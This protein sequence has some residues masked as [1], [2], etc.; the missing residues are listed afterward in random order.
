MEFKK[1][2]YCTLSKEICR[3]AKRD[4]VNNEPEYNISEDAINSFGYELLQQNKPN[5]A[6]LIF[7]LNVELY[8]NSYNVYDSYGECLLNNGKE[9]DGIAAYKKALELN[10]KNTNARQVLEKH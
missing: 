9:K 10:P 7:K 2:Y 3:I 6:E 4:I 1:E 5:D 8:P